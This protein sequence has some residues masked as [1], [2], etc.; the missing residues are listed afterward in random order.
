M[1]RRDEGASGHIPKL[2]DIVDGTFRIQDRLGGGAAGETFSATLVREWCGHP[3][4]KTIC[5]KWYKQEMFKREPS[6]NV[7]ARRIREATVGGLHSHPNLVK[8]YDT[9]E[10]WAGD[11][12]KYLLM[13]LLRGETLEEFANRGLV[14]TERIRGLLLDVANGLKALHD[15]K[16]LHRDV[17]AANVIITTEGSGVLLDLGV[18]RPESEATMTD[19]QAF[20]GTLRFAAP[21]WLFAEAFDYKSDVYS[22]GTIAYHLLTGR[23]IFSTVRLFSLLV[24]A[25]RHDDPPLL[26][27]ESDPQ[28]QYIENLTRR[29]LKRLPAERP[30]LDEV[31]DTLADVDRCRAWA[32]L[33]DSGLF[34]RMPEY[35]REDSEIQRSVVRVIKETIS[36]RDLAEII[37]HNDYD[38]L[39]GHAAVRSAIAPPGT[40][41]LVS[42]YMALPAAKRVSWATQ[43]FEAIAR[44]HGMGWGAQIEARFVLMKRLTEVEESEAIRQQLQPLLDEADADMSDMMRDLAQ[45]NP[46]DYDI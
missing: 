29:M 21:E 9:S 30:S 31:I 7:I 42:Q 27:T 4:G 5:L 23:E 39:V 11:A 6:P 35:C 15:H 19:A 44:D 22:L 43:A 18:V 37:A 36:E 8:V 24:E 28:R 34:N 46:S 12:P 20:L 41:D 10:F 33:R 32:G 25:V 40:T 14:A 26:T 2:G 16:T 38:R 1:S 45:E 17:K 13:D 3:E